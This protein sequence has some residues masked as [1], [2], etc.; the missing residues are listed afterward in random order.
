MD[1]ANRFISSTYAEMNGGLVAPA[2]DAVNRRPPKQHRNIGSTHFGKTW[3]SQELVFERA[4]TTRLQG[5]SQH[6][7]KRGIAANPLMAW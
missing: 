1:P 7:R 6:R 5:N 3:D 4:A 2:P